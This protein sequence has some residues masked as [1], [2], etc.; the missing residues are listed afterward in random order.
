MLMQR[1]SYIL[2]LRISHRALD[3]DLVSRTLGLEPH[4][5]WRTGDLR[6]TPKG[7]VLDGVRLAGYWSANPFSYGWRSSTDA[8]IEDA[9]EELME[10][11]FPHREFLNQLAESGS[12]Q[13]WVSSES[14]HNYALELP[15]RMLFR[16]ASLGVTLIHDVY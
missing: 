10:C 5:A 13:I 12:V 1:Y 16:L 11:L 15:P 8:L 14:D 9:L 7:T 6:K 3:P 2:D 4:L